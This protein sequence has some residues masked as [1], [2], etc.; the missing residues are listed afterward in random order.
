MRAIQARNKLWPQVVCTA[1]R[2]KNILIQIEWLCMV[3]GVTTRNKR[4]RLTRITGP[5][6][7]NSAFIKDFVFMKVDDHNNFSA[8]AYCGR[9]GER[10]SLALMMTRSSQRP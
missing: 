3:S 1:A 6:M 5:R 9:V 7:L 4:R 10:V 2:G 8:I